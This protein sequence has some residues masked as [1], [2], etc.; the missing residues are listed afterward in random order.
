[1]EHRSGTWLHDI[2]DN[3]HP[4]FFILG[5]CVVEN[6]LHTLKIAEFLKKLSEKL[7]INILFKS[8]FDKANRTSGTSFRGTGVQEGLAILAKVKEIFGLPIITDV[9]ECAQ[10]PMVSQVADVI[11]IPAFLCRQTDLLVAAGKTGKIIHVKKGQ[12]ITPENMQQVIEKIELSG[13]KNIWLCER[14]FSLGY[15]NLVVDYRNFPI[16]KEFKKPVIFDATHAVQRPGGLGTATGGDR[17]YAPALAAAAVVQ[18]IA[19]V[20]ME[21]HDNPEKA[22]CDGPNSIRL[23]HIE[24]VVKYLVDLDSWAKGRAVPRVF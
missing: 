17:K 7:Q 23:S 1:M 13:N 20:F 18:G 19:G 4:L 15:N 9:H 8:S 14:G 12:F 11:Q 16:M 6:E 3:Q 5:P 21:V 10:I 22:L 2:I 24:D